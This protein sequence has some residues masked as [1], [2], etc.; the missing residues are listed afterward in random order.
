MQST[1]PNTASAKRT[2]EQTELNYLKEPNKCHTGSKEG[3]GVG[4]GMEG[5]EFEGHEKTGG[6]THQVL[7]KL[8]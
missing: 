8:A 6:G 2:S 3:R 4:G 7:L 1:S 5:L